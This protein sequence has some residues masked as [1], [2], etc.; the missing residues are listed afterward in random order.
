[1]K[2]QLRLPGGDPVVGRARVVGST[3]LPASVRVSFAFLRLGDAERDRL[4]FAVFDAV[5]QNIK[6]Q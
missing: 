5:L 4:E 6:V 1:M 3:P 2:V